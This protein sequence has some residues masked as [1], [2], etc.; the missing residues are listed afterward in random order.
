MYACVMAGFLSQSRRAFQRIIKSESIMHFSDIA[1]SKNATSSM[2]TI[3]C[4]ISDGG[5][6]WTP[7]AIAGGVSSFAA[8]VGGCQTLWERRFTLGNYFAT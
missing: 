5:E 8:G 2:V 3:S 4:W 6:V 1:L 7:H